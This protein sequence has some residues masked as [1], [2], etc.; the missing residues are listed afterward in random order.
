[1]IT[2]QKDR[3]Y[4]QKGA[5]LKLDRTTSGQRKACRVAATRTKLEQKE[6]NR[7]KTREAKAQGKDQQLG[8]QQ[9]DSAP[10]AE[11]YRIG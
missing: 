10:F 5:R 4:Q 7:W 6:K 1:V 2:D 3:L 9:I 11:V 8:V